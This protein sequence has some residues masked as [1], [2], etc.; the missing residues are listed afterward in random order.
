MTD[1]Q[2]EICK[3]VLKYKT[4]GKILKK[5]K[6]D[7]YTMLQEHFSCNSLEFSDWHYDDNTQ[8]FLDRSLLEKFETRKK[9]DRRHL[10]TTIIAIC[11]AVTGT[12]SIL[13]QMIEL[14]R[15]YS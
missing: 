15:R 4:L 9:H 2:Y 3:N 10:I 12:L 13:L 14:V 5:A 7:N 1:R 11:G 8:V 6:I